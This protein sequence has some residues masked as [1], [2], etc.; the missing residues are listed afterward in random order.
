MCALCVSCAPQKYVV[1]S[2]YRP[3]TDLGSKKP[4]LLSDDYI[5]NAE[6]FAML[7]N[8]KKNSEFTQMLNQVKDLNTRRFLRAVHSLH[9]GDHNKAYYDLVALRQ[10]AFDYEV[11]MLMVDVLRAKETQ[12]LNYTKIYQEIIDSTRNE[13]IR[14]FAINRYRYLKYELAAQ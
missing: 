9:A 12:N 6:R 3:S 13:T 8:T 5:E 1:V 7:I 10:S 11:Q 14:S 2:S 4:I